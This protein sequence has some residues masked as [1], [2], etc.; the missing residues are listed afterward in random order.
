[1]KLAFTKP[2]TSPRGIK[3]NVHSQTFNQSEPQLFNTS[4]MS[5]VSICLASAYVGKASIP[6]CDTCQ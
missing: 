6:R 1:M 4:Y 5:V 2:S 3:E